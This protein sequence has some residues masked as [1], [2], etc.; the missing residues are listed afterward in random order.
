MASLARIGAKH[1]A[2]GAPETLLFISCPIA[3]ARLQLTPLP[4]AFI[5]ARYERLQA[6]AG[7]PRW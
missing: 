1:V 2:K 6:S 7:T 3:S 4:I 5:M